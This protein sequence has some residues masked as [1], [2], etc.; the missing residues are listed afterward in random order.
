MGDV[1]QIK[2]IVGV[3]RS[4]SISTLLFFTLA[5]SSFVT[6]DAST[7]PHL[8]G[9]KTS[10]TTQ[11][12]ASTRYYSVSEKPK[13]AIIIDDLGYNFRLGL[14]TISLRHPVTVAIIPFT[15]HSKSLSH[16]A[17]S[18]SKEIMLHAPMQAIGE[19]I[20]DTK[21]H[22]SMNQN[23]LNQLLQQMVADV[24][25]AKGVNNH[26]GSLFSQDPERTQWLLKQLA[27]E[28]LYFV[29]S[30]TSPETV[31][32]AKADDL[33][34]KF[35]ERDVFLDNV[36]DKSAIALQLKKLISIALKSG[37]AVGIGHPYPET[38]EVL[39]EELPKIRAQN[40][41]IVFASELTRPP[42]NTTRVSNR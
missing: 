27:H 13:V 18:N 22:T 8:A 35:T 5:I 17:Q 21:F 30:R 19:D 36:K 39:R 34:I 11:S 37:Q 7:F 28:N 38:L 42:S 23:D 26:E 10:K 24:P 32:E 33:Q 12:I 14:Q 40:I 6:G 9:Q 20:V 4:L 15:P 3:I 31:F 41:D 2:P 1:K 16:L 25:L 29:D